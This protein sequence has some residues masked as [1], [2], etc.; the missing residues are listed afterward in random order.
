MS[1][2]A[3]LAREIA[4]Y[5]QA[6]PGREILFSEI[7]KEVYGSNSKLKRD[8][9]KKASYGASLLLEDSGEMIR[10]IKL[11]RNL[12]GLRLLTEDE[13]I[14]LKAEFE[15]RKDLFRSREKGYKRLQTNALSKKVQL[16]TE[17]EPRDII[18][19]IKGS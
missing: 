4:N 8:L 5:L 13:S 12:I 17:S 10:R 2:K 18:V 1:D 16:I 7:C 6:N 19:G 3:A 9:I 14:E 11:A 15:D